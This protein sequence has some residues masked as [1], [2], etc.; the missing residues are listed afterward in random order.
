MPKKNIYRTINSLN[1]EIE[2][3]FIKIDRTKSEAHRQELKA[4]N[5]SLMKIGKKLERQLAYA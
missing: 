3:N 5:K 1:Q 4:T 2:A